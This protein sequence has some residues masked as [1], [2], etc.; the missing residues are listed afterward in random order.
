MQLLIQK[1]ETKIV[2]FATQGRWTINLMRRKQNFISF[3]KFFFR[4]QDRSDNFYVTE[5]SFTP[6]KIM[7]IT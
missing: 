4:K 6:T 2:I 1:E 3:Q 7:I 5:K